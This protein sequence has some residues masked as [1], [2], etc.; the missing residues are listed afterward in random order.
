LPGA[1]IDPAALVAADASVLEV[2]GLLGQHGHLHPID[3]LPVPRAACDLAAI[4]IRLRDD[5]RPLRYELMAESDWQRQPL[6]LPGPLR[7]DVSQPMPPL[8]A[9][10]SP[11]A[12][13]SAAADL[14]VGVQPHSVCEGD[15]HPGL[16]FCGPHGRWEWRGHETRAASW[17]LLPREPAPLVLGPGT[18]IAEETS[19]E[20]H[21]LLI[22]TCGLRDEG[23]ALGPQQA[24]VSV[25]PATQWWIDI[26]RAQPESQALLPPAFSA[27]A[28]PRPR[29]A[30]RCR[31]ERDGHALDATPL[32]RQFEDG[33]DGATA[34]GLQALANAWQPLPGLLAPRLEAR[35]GLL[36]GQ[37]SLSWGW[38]FGP[39]G[40]AGTAWMRVV[41]P[42]ALQACLADVELGGELAGGAAAPAWLADTRTRLTLRFTGQA[43]LRQ[44]LRREQ[45]KP[46]LTEVMGTALARWRFPAEL[47]LEPLATEVGRIVQPAGPVTGALVGEAGL[48]PR[49][50]GGSGWEWFAGLRIEPVAVPL[51]LEDPLLGRLHQTLALL[52]ALTLI[53]W[54]L[55]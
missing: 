42:L 31:V 16:V 43:E 44:T 11:L 1:R 23:D 3:P 22:E 30:T 2:F 35:M 52:P 50:T 18:A 12:G 17:P 7:V 26:Q 24:I 40:L 25:W 34:A 54:S 48:R 20:W 15:L 41:G 49:T 32:R 28:L 13:Q 38:H 55:G 19:P 37:A 10:L 51:V 47:L 9:A 39:G 21:R 14:Q 5:Y 8:L 53:Q 27:P 46:A 6:P 45:P 4:D 36:L 29:A 33:L